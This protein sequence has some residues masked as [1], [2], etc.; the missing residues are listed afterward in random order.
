MTLSPELCFVVEDDN[1]LVGFVAAAADAKE[2]QRRIRVA[3]I[4]EL[5]TK[6]PELVSWTSQ[7]ESDSIPSPV[8]VRYHFGFLVW[9]LCSS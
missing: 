1:A 7:L 5:E 3:W 4:P 8:K 6:Y 9:F 2:L